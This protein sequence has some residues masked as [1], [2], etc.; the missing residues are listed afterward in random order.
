MSTCTMSLSKFRTEPRPWG[1]NVLPLGILVGLG[2][3]AEG[4]PCATPGLSSVL[5]WFCAAPV[6]SSGVCLQLA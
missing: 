4:C 1:K 3:W 5:A 2:P 6:G